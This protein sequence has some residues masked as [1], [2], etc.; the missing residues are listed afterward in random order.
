MSYN[1]LKTNETPSD[2]KKK[3]NINSLTRTHEEVHLRPSCRCGLFC[4][5]GTQCAAGIS[6]TR[7]LPRGPPSGWPDDCL[8]PSRRSGIRALGEPGYRFLGMYVCK[9]RLRREK[10]KKEKEKEKEKERKRTNPLAH[11][12]TPIANA[13]AKTTLSL[14]YY[15]PP[16]FSANISFR[17]LILRI[18]SKST[19]RAFHLVYIPSPSSTTAVT[20]IVSPTTS[21]AAAQKRSLSTCMG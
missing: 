18:T 12:P 14:L 13:N 6:H 21:T 15:P 2:K 4:S 9:K 7:M 11:P 5:F 17:S 8:V 20:S 19:S 3:I 1:Q 16:T 10:R